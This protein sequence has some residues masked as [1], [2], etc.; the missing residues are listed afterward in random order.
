K[1]RKDGGDPPLHLFGQLRRIAAEWY[2][3]WL[4]CEAGTFPA[5][6]FLNQTLLDRAC[7]RI[8]AAVE[9]TYA[10]SGE[11]TAV[12]NPYNRTGS[13][14]SVNFTT[15]KD[16]WTTRADL[17]H[18][19]YAPLDSTWEGECCRMIEGHPQVR[20]Y[21]K[22]DGLGFFI[23]YLKGS[24]QHMYV[25]DFIVLVDDGHGEEDLLHMVVEVK[26]YRHEDAKE[27]KL[28]MET[29]WIPG[30]NRLGEFGRWAFV[31]LHEVDKMLEHF[32]EAVKDAFAAAVRKAVEGATNA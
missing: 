27:K 7:E 29:K 1:F 5:Q 20:A 3:N 13:T 11:I 25:P 26:G 28:T 12:L 10:G 4:K 17:C 19:N 2:R 16:T 24:E 14:A 15:T 32:D 8:R 18:V 21:V 22:N 23:P 30:V 9:L 6:I 31:E